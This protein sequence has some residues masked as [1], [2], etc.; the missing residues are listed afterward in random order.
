[1]V[2]VWVMVTNRGVAFNLD[3][4]C[5]SSGAFLYQVHL[6]PR[7]CAGGD[8][9]T[10]LGSDQGQVALSCVC[11]V[12]SSFQFTLEASHPD[13]A[14]LWHA[15]LWII[16]TPLLKRELKIY[17]NWQLAVWPVSHE[18]QN[19]DLTLE[20]AINCDSKI[21]DSFQTANTSFGVLLHH[22]ILP[23]QHLFTSHLLIRWWRMY[24]FYN[25]LLC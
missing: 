25:T 2:C 22:P 4:V 19:T 1:M 24:I 6:G 16:K 10:V 5:G 18:P 9:G 12:F 13:Y 23:T 14:L 17:V 7:D 3:N 8:K 20:N 21:S 11:S 15:L